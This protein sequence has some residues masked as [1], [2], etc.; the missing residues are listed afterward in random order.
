MGWQQTIIIGNLGHS[1]ELKEVNGSAVCNFSVA[2]T[3]KWNDKDGNRQEF[4]TWFDVACWDTLAV[5]AHQYLGKGSQV[6]VAGAVKARAYT[7]RDGSA[8][9][10]LSLTARSIQF[11]SSKNMNEDRNDNDD[12][13]SSGYSQLDGDDIPF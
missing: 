7:G 6:M 12:S 5:Q 10:S 4:T 8:K 9:A 13:D 2:V 1:P 11:L 3:D